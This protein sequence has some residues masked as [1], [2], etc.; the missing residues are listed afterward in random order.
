MRLFNHESEPKQ[1]L[2][3]AFSEARNVWQRAAT[4]GAKGVAV[5]AHQAD[6]VWN[7]TK[8]EALSVWEHARDRAEQGFHEA[9]DEAEKTW[10]KSAP[11]KKS[12]A[13]TT[14]FWVLTAGAIA[15][16]VF[17]SLD[18]GKRP[19]GVPPSER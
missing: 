18:S 9:L 13:G 3:R 12:T 8:K 1:A 5:A 14:A 2:R 19:D 4:S 17:F 15:A 11:A 10:R 7:D 6:G 16:A